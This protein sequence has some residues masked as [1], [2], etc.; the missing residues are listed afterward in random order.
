MKLQSLALTLTAC[1]S[2]VAAQGMSGLPS[3]AQA[4]ATGSIPSEC[5]LI[6]VECICAERSFINDMACCVAKSCEAKDQAAALD[7]ANGICGGAGITELPKSAACASNGTT[8]QSNATA[9][10]TATTSSEGDETSTKSST[11]T[12][13]ASS[14]ASSTEADTA[15]QSETSTASAETPASPEATDIAALLRGN[16]IGVLAAVVGGIAF[17]L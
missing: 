11:S 16:N 3:C 6:D 9:T 12:Q 4:C 7:F 8:T 2:S 5:S 17:V 10:E 14:T 13:T 1:L 15:T